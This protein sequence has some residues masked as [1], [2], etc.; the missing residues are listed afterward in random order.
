MSLDNLP[1]EYKAVVLIIASFTTATSRWNFRITIGIFRCTLFFISHSH[2]IPRTVDKVEKI[3]LSARLAQLWSWITHILFYLIFIFLSFCLFVFFF[4]SLYF[5]LLSS[6]FSIHPLYT[7][8]P[9]N[10]FVFILKA[11]GVFI[12]GLTDFLP[13]LR[14]PWFTGSHFAPWNISI[15]QS[16]GVLCNKLSW[17]F[18]MKNYS[19]HIHIS[20]LI[21][22]NNLNIRNIFQFNVNILV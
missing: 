15:S 17:N 22:F 4:I 2:S 18:L 3:H 13:Q 11:Q 21:N 14:H 19:T 16:L 12:N 7:H 6:M 1:I 20:A 10:E 8:T 5:L 9:I